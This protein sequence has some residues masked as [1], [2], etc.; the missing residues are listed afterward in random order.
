MLKIL[1]KSFILYFFLTTLLFS[2]IINRIDVFGNKR[3]SKESVIV[4]SELNTGSEYS[5]NLINS[6]LKKLYDTNFF[7]DI[8]ITFNNNK[9]SI[10]VIENPII[11]KLE[12]TG[13]K[14]KSFSEFIKESK[15]GI[16]E[17]LSI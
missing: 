16:S 8:D 13:I 2:Q 6:S 4:F 7:E 15:P 1:L 10:N 11:E 17:L 9:L 12:F 5:E 14:K 3:I